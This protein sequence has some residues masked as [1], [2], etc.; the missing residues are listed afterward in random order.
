M[1]FGQ[2]STSVVPRGQPHSFN[3]GYSKGRG[4][5]LHLHQALFWDLCLRTLI[6]DLNQIVQHSEKF[7]K[8]D[9]L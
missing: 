1:L 8:I 3:C 5:S 7:A 4:A 2:M 9:R 6:S